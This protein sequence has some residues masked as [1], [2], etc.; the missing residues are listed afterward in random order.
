MEHAWP[1]F[2]HEEME[3]H[4]GRITKQL[5][6]KSPTQVELEFEPKQPGCPG[7]WWR[8]GWQRAGFCLSGSY[9]FSPIVRQVDS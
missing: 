8:T 5:P 4:R 1:A 3:A 7:Q 2:T 9:P 6:L